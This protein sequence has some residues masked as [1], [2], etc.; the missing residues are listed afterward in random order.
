MPEYMQDQ[1]KELPSRREAWDVN[2]LDGPHVNMI[3]PSAA[4]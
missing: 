1:V 2:T 4:K 3:H